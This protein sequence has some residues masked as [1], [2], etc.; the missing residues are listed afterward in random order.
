M[1]SN[2]A[3]FNEQFE[4]GMTE[5]ELAELEGRAVTDRFQDTD[6]PEKVLN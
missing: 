5:Q 1:V 6:Y 3:V 4:D 2:D